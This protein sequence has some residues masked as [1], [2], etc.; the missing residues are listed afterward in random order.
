MIIN[1][2]FTLPLVLALLHTPISAQISEDFNDGND[3]GWTRLEPIKPFGGLT[4]FSFPGGNTYRLQAGASPDPGTVGQAR[5]GALRPEATFSSFRISIDVVDTNPVLEQDIGILARITSPGLGTLNSYAATFD[6]DEGR[7]YFSK[8]SGEE[9]DARDNIEVPTTPDKDYRL[10]FHGFQNRFLIEVFEVGDLSTPIASL[11]NIDEEFGA[12]YLEGAAGIFASSGPDDGT[13]DV[14]YDNFEASSLSDVDQDGLVDDEEFAAFG[15]L[16]E[17]GDEDFDHDGQSNAF[18]L[19]AGT[20]PSDITSSFRIL[21][22]DLVNEVIDEIPVSTTVITF[23]VSSDRNYLAARSSNLK[24]WVA[25]PDA[26]F[27]DHGDGT[28]SLTLE[29]NFASEYLRVTATR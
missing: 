20:D 22:V 14:T 3:D 7:L 27:T 2:A 26:T 5:I 29:G 25:A 6:T 23:P 13:C 15:D 9:A 10:I 19:L 24:D 12:P 21:E 4:T 18:E 17:S 8:I 1:F 11:S 28:G 16:D